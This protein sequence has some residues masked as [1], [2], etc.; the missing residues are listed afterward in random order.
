MLRIAYLGAYAALAALG[1]ALVARPALLWVR[2]LGI[3]EPVLSWEVRYG[4][5]LLGCAALV[6]VFTLWLASDVAQGKR[7]RAPLHVAFLLAIGLCF[8]IR[9]A[10]GDPQPPR[11]PAPALRDALRVAAEEL[12]R[13]YK[14]RYAPD[15]AQFSSSLAQ[16]QP[17]GFRRLGR[18]IPLHARIL[19][20]E[21]GAQVRPLE[22]DQPG[23]LYV[24]ISSDR[25][26]AW[27]TALGANGIQKLP[28]GAPAVVEAHA[29]THSLP[30]ADPLLPA[31]PRR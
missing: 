8:A 18:S 19:S 17:P 1:E 28:D 26:T 20:G 31:Y 10:S 24:A 6:A 21:D 15:A 29:G 2:S 7:P 12:D 16:V 3:L 25:Q 27:L 9:Q 4:A 14:G 11:D 5:L 13:S 30:G 23:T 22:G